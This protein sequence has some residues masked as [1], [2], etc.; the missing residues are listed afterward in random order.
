MYEFC[1]V[2]AKDSSRGYQRRYPDCRQPNRHAMEH[3]NVKETGAFMLPA[4]DGHDGR[5]VWN[6][7]E[8]VD[9]V[10]VKFK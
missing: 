5:N 8:V 9:S 3:G 4:H 1:S 2:N 7:M 6:E 10:Y